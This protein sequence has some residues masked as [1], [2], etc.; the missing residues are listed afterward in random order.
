MRVWWAVTVAGMWAY[1]CGAASAADSPSTRPSCEQA[2]AR[3][4]GT[5]LCAPRVWRLPCV[6]RPLDSCL[7]LAMGRYRNHVE[8]V[9]VTS[10]T[11][12]VEVVTEDQ[13]EGEGT[14]YPLAPGTFYGLN[15]NERHFLRAS[16]DGDMKVA[17]Y[18]GMMG[19]QPCCAF[20]C[21]LSMTVPCVLSCVLCCVSCVQR[22]CLCLC[23]CP[24]LC[25]RLYVCLCLYLCLHVCT[26]A[27]G[28]GHCSAFNPPIAGSEDH[29]EAGVYPAVGDDGVSRYHI[30]ETDLPALFKPPT[31]LAAGTRPLGDDESPRS[32]TSTADMAFCG[33]DCAAGRHLHAFAARHGTTPLSEAAY[34][35]AA[36]HMSATS[37]RTYTAWWHRALCRGAWHLTH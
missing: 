16:D 33:T 35:R 29:N 37:V 8:A 25:L 18:A 13:K 27:C 12:T 31:T 5:A 30:A 32:T 6:L 3:S 22:L 11:G 34:R 20:L 14:V 7:R 2:K 1:K 9:L 36:R 26:L 21:A 24:C 17:W 10:G 23:P 28:R 19:S 4:F 15:G